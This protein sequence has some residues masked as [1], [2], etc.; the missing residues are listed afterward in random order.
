MRSGGTHQTPRC[1]VS[2]PVPWGRVLY[3][4]V[5]SISLQLFM[6]QFV[7]FWLTF[8]IQPILNNC[9]QIWKPS[10]RLQGRAWSCLA[11]GVL[12]AIQTTWVTSWWLWPGPC[13]V[14]S[15]LHIC[16]TFTQTS[17][18]TLFSCQNWKQTPF[19]ISKPSY[20]E[21]QEDKLGLCKLVCFLKLLFVGWIMGWRIWTFA[22][23]Q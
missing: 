7:W 5:F 21:K 11:G 15:W 3:F 1:L 6:L 2:V 4:T 9:F 12:S 14:V 13:P 20:S 16:T 19:P 8:L 17:C 18:D 10:P 23:R 22:T